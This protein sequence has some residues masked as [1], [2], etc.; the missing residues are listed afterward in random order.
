MRDRESWWEKHR[1][2]VFGKWTVQGP[3]SNPTCFLATLILI[4]QSSFCFAF[5]RNFSIICVIWLD[6]VVLKTKIMKTH[7]Q[8]QESSWRIRQ[9]L[10]AI[11]ASEEEKRQTQHGKS[12]SMHKNRAFTNSPHNTEWHRTTQHTKTQQ[13]HNDQP[14]TM[15]QQ[16]TLTQRFTTCTTHRKPAHRRSDQQ[17]DGNTPISFG[18]WQCENPTP[19]IPISTQRSMV[20][21]SL[22]EPPPRPFAA[23][24]CEHFGEESRQLAVLILH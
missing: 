19:I 6:E 22:T 7:L 12:K 17:F 3:F 20:V 21:V 1:P 23:F 10:D 4:C 14:T 2:G 16:H 15:W 8:R 11:A 9:I 18:V 13:K 5:V 24:V